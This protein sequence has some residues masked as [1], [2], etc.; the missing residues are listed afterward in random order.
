MNDAE[1]KAARAVKERGSGISTGIRLDKLV[2]TSQWI[3]GVMGRTLPGQV[4]KAGLAFP[5][6]AA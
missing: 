1:S 3:E 6:L 4:A 2:E 5:E